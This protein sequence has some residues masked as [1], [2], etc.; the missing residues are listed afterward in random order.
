MSPARSK[1]N[2]NVAP[3]VRITPCPFAPLNCPDTLGRFPPTPRAELA[4]GSTGL[5]GPACN[6]AVIARLNRDHAS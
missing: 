1:L 4:S 6:M 5:D 3:T 2:A